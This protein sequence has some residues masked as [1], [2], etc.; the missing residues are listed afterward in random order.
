MLQVIQ[1]QEEPFVTKPEVVDSRITQDRVLVNSFYHRII[2]IIPASH[3]GP[4]EGDRMTTVGSGVIIEYKAKRYLLTAEHLR[5]ALG[6]IY[7]ENTNYP[8]EPHYETSLISKKGQETPKVDIALY[9]LPDDFPVDYRSIKLA[10]KQSPIASPI[11]AIGFPL[12]NRDKPRKDAVLKINSV[13][14]ADPDPD[15]MKALCVKAP[16]VAGMSGGPI[17]NSKNAL[18]GITSGTIQKIGG[19]PSYGISTKLKHIKVFLEGNVK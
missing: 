18:E 2:Q 7:I 1:A 13:I 8:D 11:T 17:L 12:T 6:K 4:N 16:L 19:R 15:L 9:S 5:G 10:E 3:T 14:I